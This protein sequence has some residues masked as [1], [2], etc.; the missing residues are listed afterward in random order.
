M[1][2]S[3]VSWQIFARDGMARLQNMIN[4]ILMELNV[5]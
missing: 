3:V 4:W 1:L 2:I 5:G